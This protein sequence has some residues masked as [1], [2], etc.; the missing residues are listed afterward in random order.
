MVGENHPWL[1]HQVPREGQMEMISACTDALEKQQSHLACAP[2]GIGKTAAALAAAL[3][4]A[5]SSPEPRTIMFLTGRQSQHKIV[6]DTVRRINMKNPQSKVS[7]VDM[8]G[9][10]GMCVEPFAG[11]GGSMFTL[12]CRQHRANRQCKPFLTNAPGLETR[13]LSDPLHVDELVELSKT[14]REGQVKTQTCPWKAA[15]LAAKKAD[16][17]VCDYNHLFI[18]EVR[19]ASLNAMELKLPEMILIVDEAHNL[20]DRVRRGMQRVL[21][22]TMVRNAVF[23]VEEH[24]GNLQKISERNPDASI[25]T[26]I[27]EWS[28][29][30]L[31]EFRSS[32]AGLFKKLLDEMGKEKELAITTSR[33]FTLLDTCFDSVAATVTQATLTGETSA[34][35]NPDK[36]KRLGLFKELLA[37]NE[38]ELNKDGDEVTEPDAHKLAHLIDSLIRFGDSPALCLVFDGEGRDGRIITHLLDPGLVSGPIFDA[39]AGTILMSG[40]LHP[41]GMY[42]DLLG[43]KPQ[44]RSVSSLESPFAK[45]RRP[46]VV[47]SDVTTLYRERSDKMT[48]N[49]RAHIMA[50]AQ[51]T[52]GNVAVF[53]P[54]YQQLKTL[55]DGM[56]VPG[57]KTILED[58][59]WGKRDVDSLLVELEDQ[60]TI[61]RRILLGGVFKGRLAEG[62]DYHGGLLDTVICV[63]IP[64]PPPSVYQNA[65][66]EYMESI[67]PGNSWRYANTQPAINTILQAMGRPIR[68][69]GDRALILL[70]DRRNE[71][72]GNQVCFPHDIKLNRSSDSDSTGRFAR[73]FFSR[74]E[75]IPDA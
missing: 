18:D 14:H 48:N 58:R 72:R 65:L 8:I 49:M 33:I 53:A 54:S 73:R 6:V 51:H 17:V 67:F 19:N 5:N 32:L 22:P 42:A 69:M 41:P 23:E 62:V 57:M 25:S 31:K 61:G 35:I 12:L 2:T 1:A 30:V 11:S 75:W 37:T 44:D 20:A 24:L 26:E 71:D 52:P 7:L 28:L 15:R 3:E 9:Q 63:G 66:R 45:E 27:K 46:I 47:A 50:A 10:S 21:T 55:F 70:L 74:V 29:N 64:F 16:I 68:A 38:T 39:V 56:Y 13:I 43:I 40:T 34:R 60:R 59:K 36:D 4:V